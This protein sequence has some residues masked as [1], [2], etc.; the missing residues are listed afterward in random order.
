MTI[1][2]KTINELR[3]LRM[4][5]PN[6]AFALASR[7]SILES[8]RPGLHYGGLFR[9]ITSPH[10][11]YVG[12]TLV[13][14]LVIS[15]FLFIPSKPVVSAAL[16][17]ENIENELAALSINVQI[18]EVAYQQNANVAIASALSEI[19]NTSVKHLNQTLLESEKETFDMKESVNPEIEKMLDAVISK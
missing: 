10:L 4:V 11:A 5:E 8:P 12:A 3:K 18:R 13:I 7:Q 6:R 14:F 2:E 9:F 17:P 16:S 1:H 19:E 15:Y